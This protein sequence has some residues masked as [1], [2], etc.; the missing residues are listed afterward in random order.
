MA[1]RTTTP[2]A[3]RSPQCAITLTKLS[4]QERQRLSKEGAC[5][6][7]HQKGHMSFECPQNQTPRVGALETGTV[8]VVAPAPQ[9]DTQANALATPPGTLAVAT[10]ASSLRALGSEEREEAR[11]ALKDLIEREDF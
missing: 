6:R 4:E 1:G 2:A 10:L 5:F 11:V 3:A 7:C 9:A 8:P